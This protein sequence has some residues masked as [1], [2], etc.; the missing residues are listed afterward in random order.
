MKCKCLHVPHYHCNWG[1]HRNMNS[2]S[3]VLLV[4]GYMGFKPILRKNPQL[5]KWFSECYPGGYDL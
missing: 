1:I 4:F 3:N 5:R 2:H